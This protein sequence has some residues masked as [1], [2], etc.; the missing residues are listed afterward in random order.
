MN[1]P[2]II[3]RFELPKD[4][5]PTGFLN[6]LKISVR[7]RYIGAIGVPPYV[8]YALPGNQLKQYYKYNS[9]IPFDHEFGTQLLNEDGSP[10]MDQFDRPIINHYVLFANHY[11]N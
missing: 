8:L 1:T 2:P 4:K 10:K 3:S 9:I 7:K 6:G 11:A 5:W